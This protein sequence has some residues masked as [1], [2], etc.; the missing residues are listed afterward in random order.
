MVAG[1]PGITGGAGP[2]HTLWLSRLAGHVCALLGI[3]TTEEV[4][5]DMATEGIQASQSFCFGV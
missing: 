5:L 3:V 2:L 4:L 1:G